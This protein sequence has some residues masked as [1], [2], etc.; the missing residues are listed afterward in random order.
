MIQQEP[1]SVSFLQQNLLLI[2]IVVLA[3]FGYL[4]LIIRKRWKKNFLHEKPTKG[5]D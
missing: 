2:S 3:I 1:Q 4:V 5:G